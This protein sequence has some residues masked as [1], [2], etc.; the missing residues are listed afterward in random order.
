MTEWEIDLE[1]PIVNM[2]LW[3][4]KALSHKEKK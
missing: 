2:L 3:N 4:L 1:K